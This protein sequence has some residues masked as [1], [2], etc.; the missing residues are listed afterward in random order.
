[1]EYKSSFNNQLRKEITARAVMNK[2]IKSLQENIDINFEEIYNAD[3]EIKRIKKVILKRKKKNRTY[4]DLTLKV[5]K[6]NISKTNLKNKI[7]ALKQI[8][9]HIE[10]AKEEVKLK[11]KQLKKK[12]KNLPVENPFDFTDYV[13]KQKEENE[14]DLGLFIELAEENK[15][16]YN[17]VPINTLIED[18][19]KLKNGFFT[20][21]Y[22][23]L[24]EEGEID[25]N[26]FFKDSDELAKFIDK[27]L[28]K[29]DNHPSI[30]YTGNIYRYFKNYKRINRSEHGRGA[31]EFN[32]IE[33]YNGNNCYIPSGNGCFLK[34]IN[35]IFKRDFSIE[36]F[37]FIKSYKRRPNV[38]S[39]CRIPEFCNRYKIDIGIYD[40]NKQRILPRTVNQRDKCV[41]I[42]RNHYCVIWKKNRKDS[43]LN[44][45]KEVDENFRYVKNKINEDNLKQ[46]IRY[47]FPK[48]EKI[49]QLKNVFVFDLETQNDQEFAEAYAAGLYDV[50]R[51]SHRWHRDLTPHELVIERK[52]VTV[53][54]ASNGNCIMNMLKYISENYEGDERTYIDREGDEIVSSY[55]LLLVAHNSSGFDS[56]VVLN[57]LIK[58]ITD[59]K[60]IKT[61][62]GLISL[63]FRCGVK[64]VN[65]VE[66]HQYVKFTCSKSHI[67]GSL[68]KIGKE[69]GLQPKLLKGEMDHSIINKNNFVKLRHIWEP[70]LIT[71]V[72]CLAFIYARHSMEMQKMTGFGIKDC[73]TEASLGW[74][75]FG[76]Y[77][78][79]REFYTFNDKYVR[80]FIRK[81]IKG[82]RVGAF[83]RYFESNQCE[84][85]LNTIKKHLKINDNE[86]S[87]II[88]KYLKYINTKRNEFKLEFENGEKDYRKINNKELDKFLERKLGELNISKELQ[89]IN[90]DDLLVSYDFNSLYPSAQIDKDSNWPKIE[91]AYP[92]KK[93]MND[94]ICTLFNSGRWN[95][96]NRSAFLTIK[97]HNP[98]NLIFQHLPV[99]EKINNPYKNN[100]LEEINRMRNGI[101]IDTLT[102]VDIVEIVK[103][104]GEILEVYEGFFCYNLEFN[105][106]TEFVTDMFQKR[107]LFKSQGKDLLQN[108]A[109]KIGL[110]VYGGNIRKDINEE[111]KCV[112][113]NWMRENFD[114][115]VK[116]WFP[117]KNGNLI[118]KLEDDEGVDDFD[119]AKSINTMPSHFGSYILSHSKRLMNSVIKQIDGFYNNN[120]YYTDTDSLYIHKKYWSTLVEKGFVGKT[121][122][123]GKNDYGN[124]GIF[125]AWF[126][127]PKIKYCLVIDDFGIISA[128]RT[129]NGYSEEHRMIKLEE[130][131]S[132][133]EGKT[134]S[135]RFSIDWTKTF[136]G[137][138]IPHR[139][140]NCSECDNRKFCNDC[141]EKPKKNCFNCEMEKACDP[142]LNLISQKKNYS[143]DINTLKRKPPNEYHQMLPHYEGVYEPKQNNINFESAKEILMKED[144][145]MVAKRRFERIYTALESMDYTK[146]EDIS[147]NKEIF[148]YGIKH[149][150]TD[151][152]DNYI[153]IGC[154]SDELYENDK[155]F[156]FWSNKYINNEIEKRNFQISGWP[157]ITLVKRNNFFKIQGI[158]S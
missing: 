20:N 100:R 127:A 36:Y 55:R 52:N 38:M 51:L 84:E 96:L 22:F 12:I 48:Y 94:A 43:L 29:Y 99:K 141:G 115:R 125:Y 45:V 9:S 41:H 28:D 119:K 50:N 62:R 42:H 97:Y 56:W 91:T 75:C 3:M 34:C 54:D 21:G 137:I 132:L 114:D 155:L 32:N 39:R 57:S 153:L 35:Y 37:E 134:V 87:N 142:C 131:I 149:V 8:I 31:N 5:N 58:E 72:L 23:T 93:F 77:N 88:D 156:N 118:V 122:G 44:G 154:E 82:G 53:F 109:K 80:D 16:I 105:P 25:T 158:I 133:S 139:K 147:E 92:F 102:S 143:T 98:E 157:F 24:G 61:A 106:Y 47:R 27:I 6:L 89:K 18:M 116:E 90:K 130:Y 2:E 68:E 13:E 111:Y 33:E 148:I 7:D 138:K 63:S 103:Y 104:G 95:E 67:K 60:I 15:I 65:S 81:S 78:K 112:T 85:I 123:L 136:E 150:K 146:Y 17:Q 4:T 10:Q 120:I 76:T 69:Y 74:K 135:G 79:N 108:L 26:R 59:L 101:I 144:Y 70:Y 121:L 152:I 113:E 49:D 107:D 83:N 46:R 124:S 11:I 128:K 64:I 129:F 1:M 86:I 40:L 19:E 145:K 66:V 151:K 140:Q 110:S 73:L 126:L 117:L 30:Y 71:D 14:I